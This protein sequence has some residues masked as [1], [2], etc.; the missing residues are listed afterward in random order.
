M[1]SCKSV[2]TFLSIGAGGCASVHTTS[3]VAK[4][5]EASV[6]EK[7]DVI[8]FSHDFVSTQLISSKEVW[9]IMMLY[10]DGIEEQ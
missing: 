3:E 5:Q 10:F 1:N 4:N 2:H 9:L 6:N 7:R 8:V